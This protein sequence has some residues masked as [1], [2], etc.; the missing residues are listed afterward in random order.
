MFDQPNAGENLWFW[1]AK[2]RIFSK[3]GSEAQRPEFLAAT[4]SKAVNQKCHKPSMRFKLGYFHVFPYLGW[5]KNMTPN[6]G[7]NGMVWKWWFWI[8]SKLNSRDP[9]PQLSPGEA[10]SSASIGWA[11]ADS[12]FWSP[13]HTWAVPRSTELSLGRKGESEIHLRRSGIDDPIS[14]A[15]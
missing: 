9:N 2:V 4:T 7:L 10:Y 1:I 12:P 14:E 3:T 11:S 13:L 6:G 8:Q 5:C 15:S